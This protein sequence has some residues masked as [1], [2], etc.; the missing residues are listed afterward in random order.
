MYIEP[1]SSIP[2][3]AQIIDRIRLALLTGELRPGD[4][5]PSIRDVEKESGIGRN[6]VRRAYLELE[7]YGILKLKHGKGVIVRDE[8]PP[9]VDQAVVYRTRKLCEEVLSRA[10]ALGVTG[11]SFARMLY[12]SALAQERSQ[13]RLFYV[14][15]NEPLA[16]ERATQ[17]SRAWQTTIVGV[18]ID[19]IKILE[20]IA[21]KTTLKIITNFYRYG[22][23]SSLISHLNVP[24][25]PIALK[26]AK[27]MIEEI[28][29]LHE[30]SIVEIVLDERDFSS[31]GGLILA[32][33]Q[34][35]FAAKR[36]TFKV[37]ALTTVA[38][39]KKRLKS[40]ECHMLVISNKLWEKMPEDLRRL[41]SV[42]RPKMEFDAQASESARLRAG[43]IL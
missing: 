21:Q 12:Y 35:T 17:I 16:Q 1:Y 37:V 42:T 43:I 9:L 28:N 15:I 11:S 5:L 7:A 34:R 40:G 19:R 36:V 41:K 20:E 33:Y 2:V 23:V 13:Q 14:D 22:E 27:E 4:T 10:A 6:V 39:L 32:N 29:R 26:F 24:I 8:L 3:H 38:D 30:G 31:Y 25:I 18:S